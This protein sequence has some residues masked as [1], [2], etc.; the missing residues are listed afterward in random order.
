[1]Q[2]LLITGVLLVE[3]RAG[4]VDAQ[5]LPPQRDHRVRWIPSS[6]DMYSLVKQF[7][8]YDQSMPKSPRAVESWEE[9]AIAYRA[10]TPS[11]RSRSAT[12]R[13]H[14]AAAE[15]VGRGEFLF[16]RCACKSPIL[17]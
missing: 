11:K 1:L 3:A 17:A 13:R 6:D 10:V 9:D 14:A 15:L 16:H 12:D 4:A 8:D 7:Y 2:E 5:D